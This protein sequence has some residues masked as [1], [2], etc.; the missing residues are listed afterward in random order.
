L[1]KTLSAYLILFSPFLL[2]SMEMKGTAET[3]QAIILYDNGKWEYDSLSAAIDSG[4]TAKGSSFRGTQWG[5]SAS[6]IRKIEKATIDDEASSDDALVYNVKPCGLNAILVYSFINNKL[7][8]AN[9]VFDESYSNLNSYID[10]YSTIKEN[11]KKAYGKP[12]T[13]K[14]KWMDSLY[15]NDRSNHGTA[16]LLGL[17]K[18][19]AIWQTASTII[20]IY[21]DGNRSKI[22]MGLEYSSRE[23]KMEAKKVIEQ[24][25]TKDL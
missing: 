18:K 12:K 9:Y 10:D 4:S 16:V 11:L 14:I 25:A 20:I 23:L 24:K 3:G 13:D 1:N 7:Y 6:Q 21:L 8:K 2:F 17:L 5:Q 15:K 22:R 19:N